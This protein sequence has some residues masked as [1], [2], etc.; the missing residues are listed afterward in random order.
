M[1]S[2]SCQ[3]LTL[4]IKRKT[5]S[6]TVK[7]I[8][9]LKGIKTAEN[10]EKDVIRDPVLRRERHSFRAG[11]LISSLQASQNDNLLKN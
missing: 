1:Y 2:S 4:A 5:S 8:Q 6:T 10:L 7:L 3:C 9:I 11:Y